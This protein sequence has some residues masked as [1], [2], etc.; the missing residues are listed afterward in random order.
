MS[1]SVYFPPTNMTTEVYD[2]GVSLL[3]AAGAGSPPGREYHACFVIS[4]HTAVLDVW[5]SLEEF[6]AFGETLMPILDKLGV[7]MP[8]PQISE[9]HNIIR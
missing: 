9:I 1:I 6:E 4:G 5:T 8:E 7:E 3:E 2:E